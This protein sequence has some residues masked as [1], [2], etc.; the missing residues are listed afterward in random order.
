MERV[1]LSLFGWFSAV[2]GAVVLTLLSLALAFNPRRSL[3][4]IGWLVLSLFAL[5]LFARIGRRRE[6]RRRERE[7][8]KRAAA[9]A[10]VI[11]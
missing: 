5:S 11:L 7:A 4:A 3:P 1:P 6:L 10:E 9:T 8:L 2:M